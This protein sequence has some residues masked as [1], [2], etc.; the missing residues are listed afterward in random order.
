MRIVMSFVLGLIACNEEKTGNSVNTAPEN[1][2]KSIVPTEGVTT[3]T[4]LLC[5]ATAIDDDND[6]L[7]L[8]YQWTNGNGDILGES[9]TLLLTPELVVP[10]EE[11]TCTATVSD[12]LR[13]VT[14]S[15]SVVVEPPHQQFLVCR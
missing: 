13:F 6:V 15:T 7:S 3:L 12:T 5:V 4:E 10:T 9:G 2:A 8:S 11:L 1:R 14:M